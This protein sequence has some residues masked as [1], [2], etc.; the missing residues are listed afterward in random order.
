MCH[1]RQVRARQYF[2]RDSDKG[3]ANRKVATQSYRSKEFVMSDSMTAGPPE[4]NRSPMQS[5]CVDLVGDMRALWADRRIA[6]SPWN[7]SSKVR[8][9][10]SSRST[11][12]VAS[13]SLALS[14]ERSP[15]A[16]R[17]VHR[18]ELT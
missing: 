12:F 5:D 7:S 4:S 6:M 3:K 8:S 13:I 14:A 17:F 9:L 10:A 15:I 1:A 11:I 18:H 2:V 16:A